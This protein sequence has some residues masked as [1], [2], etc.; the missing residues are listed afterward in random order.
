MSLS[1]PIN[2]SRTVTALATELL[3]LSG[4][5]RKM[6]QASATCH[7]CGAPL[8]ASEAR[9]L[10]PACLLDTSLNCEDADSDVAGID[11]AWLEQ[12]GVTPPSAAAQV[13]RRFGDYELFEEIGRGGMGVIYRALQVSLQRTV[14][15]KTILTDPLASPDF[16]QRFQTEAHAAAVLDHPNIVPIYEVGDHQGQPYYSMPLISGRNLAEALKQDG[17]LPPRQAATLIASVARAIHYAHQHG[18][19]HRDLKPANILL[20]ANSQP[21]VTDFGLAKLL[22]EDDG[23]TLTLAALGTPNYMAP[24]QAAGKPGDLTTAADTYSLGAILFEVLT[25]QRLFAAATPLAT[26]NHARDQEPPRPSTV[27]RAI[28]R[29][30]DTICLKC[31]E[32]EPHRR[33]ATAQGLAEDLERWLAGE[34]IRARRVGAVER[35][36]LWCRRKPAMAGMAGSALVLVL[37]ASGIATWRVAA[38]RHLKELEQYSANISLADAYL[39]DGAVDR[40]LEL[41]LQCPPKLRHWEWGRLLYQ[42]HQEVASIPAHTNRAQVAGESLIQRLAVNRDG[43]RLATHAEDGGLKL[44]DSRKPV[45]LVE[46]GDATN[47]V[48]AWAFQPEGRQLVVGMQ[49]GTVHLFDTEGGKLTWSVECKAGAEG[50]NGSRSSPAPARQITWGDIYRRGDLPTFEALTPL[51]QAVVAL[52]YSPEGGKMAIATGNGEITVRDAA[53]GRELASW[54]HGLLR[55]GR[56]S[57]APKG[58]ALVAKGG[59]EVKRFELESGK[60]LATHRWDPLEQSV[61]FVDASGRNAATLDHDRNTQLWRDGQKTHLLARGSSLV[62]MEGAAPAAFFFDANGRWVCLTGRA[63]NAR[64]HEVETGRLMFAVAHDVIGG[65]FNPEGNCLVTFGP[66]RLIRLWDVMRGQELRVLRGH[67]SVPTEARFSGDGNFIATASRDGVTKL[68]TGRPGRELVQCE[69]LPM[70]GPYSADGRQWATA[71][72]WNGIYVCDA[73][74]GKVA[75]AF[76]LHRAQVLRAAFS[77]DGRWLATVGSEKF[78]RIWDVREQ[79]L[80]GVLQGHDRAVLSVAWSMDGKRIAT[81]DSGGVARIWNATTRRE[82]RTIRAQTPPLLCVQ[83]DP[84]GRRLLTTGYGAPMVWDVEAG[85]EIWRLDDEGGQCYWATFSPDGRRIVSPCVDR[86]IRFWDATTGRLVE[87]WASRSTGW[88]VCGYS[89]DGRRLV[90]SVV[91]HG[92][93]GLA[94]PA[95]EVWDTEHGRRLLDLQGHTDSVYGSVFSP[96]GDRVLTTAMDQTVRHWESFPWRETEYAQFPG[97]TLA[98]RIRGYADHYWRDRIAAER[99][100][101]GTGVAGHLGDNNLETPRE[102][103]ALTRPARLSETTANLL[104]LDPHYTGSLDSVFYPEADGYDGDDD[105]SRLPTGVGSFAGVSFD[106]RGVL[107]L[108]LGTQSPRYWWGWLRHPVGVEGIRVGSKARRIHVLHAAVGE[109]AASTVIGSYVLR[110][111]DGTQQEFEIIYGRDLRHW[112]QGGVGDP[113]AEVL[114]AKVAWTGSNP[115]ADRYKASVRLFVRTY[116]NPRPDVEV[117][118]ID[119]VSKLTAAAPFLVA[120]TVEP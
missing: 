113:V 62:E 24:E 105:L 114:E 92:T 57:F 97:Q 13:A 4:N 37:L 9:G 1:L 81:G 36:G 47:A 107:L 17:P 45:P 111:A 110:Y 91:D 101:D 64:V 117:V 90:L 104:N 96:Q 32:K 120:M 100:G 30:L 34:P 3:R 94:A 21:H 112:W 12:Q 15:V 19:L 72:M 56:L 26:I 93:L 108:R 48:S 84:A 39:R 49:N 28:P 109:A 69:G 14:A 60:V 79:R 59:L 119:F 83:F 53:T 16:V 85:G 95:V 102:W 43:T 8:N 29:D 41:L 73:D 25:G 18:V 106:V 2:G 33:Y 67:L 7:S 6:I 52:A 66:D 27:L 44:W 76:P 89:P 58:R 87:R 10:C 50:N 46:W 77:P 115:V 65:A 78:A 98:D 82:T 71:P 23:L 86:Q 35:L 88:A 40:A 31:L 54:R 38:A 51:P 80:A 99:I 42:C 20:D 74:S 116:E 118:S 11:T 61:L 63:G 55:L 70:I 68:W 75:S 22:E 103:E 5:H